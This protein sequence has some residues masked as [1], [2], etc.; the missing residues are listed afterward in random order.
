MD[1]QLSDL[2]NKCKNEIIDWY[3]NQ[4][5]KQRYVLGGVARQCKKY[6]G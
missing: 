5:F 6:V 1:I 4:H 3:N 2:Q